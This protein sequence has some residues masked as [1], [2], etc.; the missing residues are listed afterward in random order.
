VSRDRF[1]DRL[2]V[3][4]LNRHKL[5]QIQPWISDMHHPVAIRAQKGKI[6]ESGPMTRR[7]HRQRLKVMAL[8]KTSAPISVP[9]SK[10]HAASLASKATGFRQ[11]SVLLRSPEPRVSLT[12][13]VS[14]GQDFSLRRFLDEIDLVS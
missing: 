1:R 12:D 4:L 6:L 14:P 13:K 3:R 5:L 10:I 8:D 7:Q 11:D 2:N 9:L